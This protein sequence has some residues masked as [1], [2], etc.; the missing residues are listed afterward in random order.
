MDKGFE[1]KTDEELV[2]LSLEDQSA[3][4]ML[5]K[6]YEGKLLSYIKRIS[7]FAIEDAQD[8]LQDVFLSVYLNLRKFNNE[9]KFSSWIYRIT[10]NKTIS[11][12]RKYKKRLVVAEVDNNAFVELL[13]GIT[14][15]EDKL[16]Q[17]VLASKV[18]EEIQNM[19]VKYKAVL[20]LRYLE[21][22]E[23]NEISD[24]LKIPVSNVGVLINRAKK[25][26]KDKLN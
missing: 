12:Y 5:M 9:Y 14:D 19:D 13:T 18:K 20:V 2:N 25:I 3:Y 17:E 24:I 7:G 1:N 10:H 8:V 21:N 26:L 11:F 23:Y 4:L 6:R 22:K 16:T 15:E